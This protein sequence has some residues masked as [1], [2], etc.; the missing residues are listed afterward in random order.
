MVSL[1]IK[2]TLPSCQ[3]NFMGFILWGLGL[4]VE[5]TQEQKI[6][7]LHPDLVGVCECKV[8]HCCH[9]VKKL[10]CVNWI[11]K[12]VLQR[13]RKCVCQSTHNG[14][15]LSSTERVESLTL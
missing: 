8:T 2:D 4:S 13:L 10:A 14:V 15:L 3:S 7:R 1:I 5:G 6:S 11:V 12:C 9:S